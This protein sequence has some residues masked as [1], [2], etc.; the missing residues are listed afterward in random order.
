MVDL[1]REIKQELVQKVADKLLAF[2]CIG[3]LKTMLKAKESHEHDTRS[4]R[5]GGEACASEAQTDALTEA[6]GI[7]DMILAT[8]KAGEIVKS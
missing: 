3:M 7:V 8:A 6:N 1:Q 2:H 5:A 4:A